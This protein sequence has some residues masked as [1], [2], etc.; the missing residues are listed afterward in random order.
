MTAPVPTTT[1]GDDVYT[2]DP[3]HFRP[4]TITKLQDVYQTLAS[5]TIDAPRGPRVIDYEMFT[6]VAATVLNILH[7]VSD[8]LA[9][10][11]S[12][13]K[14]DTGQ[15]GNTDIAAEG[16]ATLQLT[17]SSSSTTTTTTTWDWDDIDV[18]I[19]AMPAFSRLVIY[20]KLNAKQ[21]RRWL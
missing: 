10:G 9:C 6:T 7:S 1:N 4:L 15:S 21:V 13:S 19:T 3:N 14:P 16:D 18:L 17:S 2:F 20:M 8:Q 12:L 5:T 11:R